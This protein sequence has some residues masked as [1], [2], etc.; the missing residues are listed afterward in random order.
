MDIFERGKWDGSFRSWEGL[1]RAS[2]VRI[3]WLEDMLVSFPAEK[4]KGPRGEG[5]I[6][7]TP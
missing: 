3:K 6:S 5:G 1:W 2:L 4:P 7:S